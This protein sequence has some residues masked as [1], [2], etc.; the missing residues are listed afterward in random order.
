MLKF[1][2]RIL[3]E[4]CSLITWLIAVIGSILFWYILYMGYLAIV[5]R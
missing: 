2:D 1:L 4:Y 3:R 5:G